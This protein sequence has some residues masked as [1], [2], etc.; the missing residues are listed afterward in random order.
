MM[1]LEK[2]KPVLEPEVYERSMKRT[3][4]LVAEMEKV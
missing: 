4:E 2:A 1:K 3:K